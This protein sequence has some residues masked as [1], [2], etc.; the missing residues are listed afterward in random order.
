MIAKIKKFN[1]FVW[2]KWFIIIP[3]TILFF[4]IFGYVR[5]YHSIMLIQNEIINTPELHPKEY[6]EVMLE[7]Y[8]NFSKERIRV[9]S[10]ESAWTHAIVFPSAIF[11][12]IFI[13]TFLFSE[14]KIKKNIAIILI[15]LSVLAIILWIIFINTFT[16]TF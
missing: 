5:E 2:K 11:F 4:F 12:L 14:N 15:V 10:T 6:N 7:V 13:S 16:I 8:D 1:S 9:Y 3:L